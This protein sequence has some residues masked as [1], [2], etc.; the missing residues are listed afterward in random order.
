VTPR[1][2]KLRRAC[3]IGIV[4]L[5]VT[6]ALLTGHT[7]QEWLSVPALFFLGT[8]LAIILVGG[9]NFVGATASLRSSVGRMLLVSNLG[10]VGLF[11]LGIAVLRQ[12]QVFALLGLL[13][14]LTL[15]QAAELVRV[16]ARAD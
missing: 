2:I 9:W 1:L 14:V 13:A 5:G 10:G 4:A 16:D 12:L 11:A 8:G 7:Y 6:H 15:L 3:A